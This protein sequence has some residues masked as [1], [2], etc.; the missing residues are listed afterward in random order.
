MKVLLSGEW[1]NEWETRMKCTMNCGKMFFLCFLLCNR[2]YG[3][4]LCKLQVRQKRNKINN[5]FEIFLNEY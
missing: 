4:L 1:R 3:Q 2:N 5:A